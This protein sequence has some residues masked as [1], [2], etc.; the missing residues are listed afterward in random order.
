MNLSKCCS[1]L[2]LKKDHIDITLSN[3]V[4]MYLSSNKCSFYLV[5]VTYRL[6]DMLVSPLLNLMDGPN[7]KYFSEMFGLGLSVLT[8]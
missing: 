1:N 6:K 4:H 8:P 7:K 5:N 2:V 3:I